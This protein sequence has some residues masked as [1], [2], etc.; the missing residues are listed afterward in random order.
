MVVGISQRRIRQS[1]E[2]FLINPHHES[3]RQ[4]LGKQTRKGPLPPESSVKSLPYCFPDFFATTCQYYVNELGIRP[5]LKMHPPGGHDTIGEEKKTHIMSLSAQTRFHILRS[6]IFVVFCLTLTACSTVETA[7]ELPTASSVDLSRY[8][9]T[10]YEIARLPMWA[11]RNCL[12]ST[13][14]YRLLDSG[15]VSV[16]NMCVTTT[17]KEIS[18]EGMA[19]VVDREHR[20][21]LNVV[22]DQWAAKLVALFT[23][24]DQGNYWILRVDPDY[25]LAVVGTPDRDYLWILSKT[26][27]LDEAS[28]Q[29]AVTF[30]QHLG[31]HTEH[32]I[33]APH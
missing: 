31:F 14:E 20:A 18:I 2:A 30:A 15:E 21:K 26:P 7:G 29:D 3:N 13:A 33:R 10:W 12:R 6:I 5:P 16:R 27:L 19:T 4:L 8:A 23:W 9:G 11:Q 17:G 32:L 25:R 24:A 22:F 28:Y 1:R